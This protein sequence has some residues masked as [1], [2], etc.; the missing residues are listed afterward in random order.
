LIAKE[1]PKMTMQEF[2]E[3]LAAKQMPENKEFKTIANRSTLEK[4]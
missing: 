4:D 1:N 3:M 2:D